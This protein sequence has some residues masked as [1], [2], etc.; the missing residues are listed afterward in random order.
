MRSSPPVGPMMTCS[1]ERHSAKERSAAA[2]SFARFAA[3]SSI[4]AAALVS[5][6]TGACGA[7][8]AGSTKGT[9]TPRDGAQAVPTDPRDPK[10]GFKLTRVL[11]APPAQAVIA[12]I[13]R[14]APQ[15]LPSQIAGAQCQRVIVRTD[16]GR[17][18]G[19]NIAS[20]AHDGTEQERSAQRLNTSIKGSTVW[21]HRGIRMRSHGSCRGEGAVS[22][23]ALVARKIIKQD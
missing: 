7:G 4:G 23:L 21:Q 17:P 16:V 13:G 20:P 12:L 1:A 3:A 18:G 10:P 22:L 19:T 8:S 11:H 14:I 15:I 9:E 5:Q 6:Q 2:A